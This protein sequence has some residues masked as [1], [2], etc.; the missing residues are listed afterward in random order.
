MGANLLCFTYFFFRG[1]M[2]SN[3][4]CTECFL[5]SPLVVVCSVQ[6]RG[7]GVN[8]DGLHSPPPLFLSLSVCL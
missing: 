6:C 1:A 4:N 2:K 5:L 8:D 7:S 3:V